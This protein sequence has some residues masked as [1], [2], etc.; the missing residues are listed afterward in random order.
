MNTTPGI[1]SGHRSLAR[2]C[3]AVITGGFISQI[4]NQIGQGPGCLLW[5]S[6]KSDRKEGR[7]GKKPPASWVHL[8]GMARTPVLCLLPKHGAPGLLPAPPSSQDPQRLLAR[9]CASAYLPIER[10]QRNRLSCAGEQRLILSSHHSHTWGNQWLRRH[11]WHPS[12]QGP[13]GPGWA[14]GEGRSLR[15]CTLLVRYHHATWLH[16]PPA[17]GER[18]TG[19]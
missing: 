5:V 17:R 7:R 14:R 10:F 13:G 15:G 4:I 2:R 19:V 1:S 3:P 9:R 18:R 12:P 8:L 11:G 16:L 6:K